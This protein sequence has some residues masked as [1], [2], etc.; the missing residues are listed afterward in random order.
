MDDETVPIGSTEVE[1]PPPP[2]TGPSGSVRPAPATIDTA[3]L[4][5]LQERKNAET[6][7][8]QLRQTDQMERDRVRAEAALNAT[9]VQ[10]GELQAWD[11]E[12]MSE[13]YRTDPIEAF[14][15]I[16]SVFAMV[17]SAFT[18]APMENALNGAAAAMQAVR[19]GN[20]QEFDRAFKAW[21]ENTDLV[22]KRHNIQQ[23][24]Y[25]NAS[26]MM[27]TNMA[28]GRAQMEMAA[29]R[30]GDE[31]ALFLLRNG[32]DKELIDLQ[33]SNNRA[34]QGMEETAQTITQNRMRAQL[35][36]QES[37]EIERTIQDPVE[38][39]GHRLATWNR[40]YGKVGTPQQ[41]AF[42]LL[43]HEMRGQPAE[44]I[45]RRAVE[46][47]L[48]PN[49]Q[50]V[51]T[52]DRMGTE[53]IERRKQ[54]YIAQGMDPQEAFRTAVREVD[55]EMARMTGGQIERI[56]Q[57]SD[58]TGY[59]IQTID[60]LLEKIKR[61]AGPVGPYGYAQRGREIIG[62]LLGGTDSVEYQQV[63]KDISQLRIWAGQVLTGR[64]GRL[65]A[66]EK[67]DLERVITGLN[68]TDTTQNTIKTYEELRKLYTQIQNDM[69]ARRTRTRVAP[70]VPGASAPAGSATPP[71]SRPPAWSDAPA[72]Q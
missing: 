19:A 45:A 60:K 3:P 13:R 21:R 70:G 33:I 9:G 10:P 56:E 18:G 55:T 57:A 42:G 46:L 63:A 61:L 35:W 26:N 30:F 38:A 16:G 28:A 67:A 7:A 14:G 6:R 62:N 31:K 34:I 59:S 41:E 11:H 51:P 68:L 37:A 4:A 44:A 15:S 27:T 49:P 29:T 5:E 48:M 24:Y 17:A 71:P 54:R 47:G 66:S 25:T 8:L 65:L 72:V 53:E 64:F 36:D 43:M 32:F 69:E 50:G 20:D 1:A 2:A 12:R 58:L 40:V 39:A 52:R 22:I 23:Q